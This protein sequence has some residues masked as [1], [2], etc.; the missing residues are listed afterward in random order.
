MDTSIT[1]KAV[2]AAVE[3]VKATTVAGVPVPV[4]AAMAVAAMIR[5][6]AEAMVVTTT[7]AGTRVPITAATATAH[8][9]VEL[10]S[11]TAS[12]GASTIARSGSL[13]S[14]RT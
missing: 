6:A 1:Q 9:A 11:P 13:N 2:A 4:T 5:A 14:K 12:T 8:A 7:V 10:G 3:D